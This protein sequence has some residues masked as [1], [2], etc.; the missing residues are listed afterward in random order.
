MLA[1][2]RR[3][4][5]EFEWVVLHHLIVARRDAA[6]IQALCRANLSDVALLLVR[7]FWE[8]T[9]RLE[10][11]RAQ[12]EPR[13]RQ[14]LEEAW[15]EDYRTLCRARRR[16]ASHA[17]APFAREILNDPRSARKI[18]QIEKLAPKLSDSARQRA[19]SG[20]SRALWSAAQMAR[21]LGKEEE[22]EFVYSFL[23]QR[24]HA[25][26]D[27]ARDYWS[28]GSGGTFDFQVQ[29][30][31]SMART[32]ACA[33]LLHVTDVYFEILGLQERKQTIRELVGEVKS[34]G[35][36]PLSP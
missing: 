27:I 4:Q 18:E 34:L 28:E 14:F 5:S 24:A 29:D 19:E 23:S 12:V 17:A 11:I 36:A 26:A 16:V 7:R 30:Y 1:P 8:N 9:I 2:P 3:P 15:V 6:G 20:S 21:E 13:S 10:Y 32:L 25:G 31:S 22:Y 33:W 35:P